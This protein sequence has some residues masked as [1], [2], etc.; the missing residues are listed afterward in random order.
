MNDDTE[1]VID[2]HERAKNI[3][4]DLLK[5]MT[6]LLIVI[7]FA[8][9]VHQQGETIDEIRATQQSGSPTTKRL[10]A[11]AEQNQEL[12]EQIKSCTTPSGECAKAGDRKTA[13]AILGIIAGGKKVTVDVIVAALSC[14]ADGITGQEALARC[15]IE[16]SKS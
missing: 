1:V 3:V 15:T 11:I 14:N 6:V 12:S 7:G 9:V 2:K 13:K 16:R 5:Y 8:I 10:I 4:A